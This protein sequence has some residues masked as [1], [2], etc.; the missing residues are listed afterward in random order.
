MKK[1]HTPGPWSLWRQGIEVISD[2]DSVYYA[3][4]I[5]VVIEDLP[6]SLALA[7]IENSNGEGGTDRRVK[8][9]KAECMANARLM[10]TA[11]ELLAE[12]L[13]A[14]KTL[15]KNGNDVSSIDAVLAKVEGKQ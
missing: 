4:E 5:G 8:I 9:G 11:P 15:I 2:P 7:P 3:H 6:L 1:K 13:K 14:R 12:L 10:A